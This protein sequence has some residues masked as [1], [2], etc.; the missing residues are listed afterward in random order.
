MFWLIKAERFASFQNMIMQLIYLTHIYRTKNTNSNSRIANRKKA[1][2]RGCLLVP[3]WMAPLIPAI[4][5][6]T[7]SHTKKPGNI[8]Q[9]LSSGLKTDDVC[10]T[11]H[12]SLVKLY[13]VIMFDWVVSFMHSCY[14]KMH[15][16]TNNDTAIRK[17][18][19]T[20]ELQFL[21]SERSRNSVSDP[22]LGKFIYIILYHSISIYTI[23]SNLKTTTFA[24]LFWEASFQS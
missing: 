12:E 17:S 10:S 7:N 11:C 24:R 16:K 4:N 2:P 14:R 3:N 20:F 18:S 5:T 21:S 6:I 23:T 13:A 8:M 19:R 15:S 9:Q 22:Y 1:Y